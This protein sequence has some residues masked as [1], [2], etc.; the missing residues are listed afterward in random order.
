M[1]MGA[2]QGLIGQ[3]QSAAATPYQNYGGQQ[4]ADLTGNQNAGIN[5]IASS[6]GIQNPYLSAAGN[7]ANIGASP[8]SSSSIQGYMNPYT[9]NVINA[10]MAQSQQQQQIA[11]NQLQGNATAMGGLGNNRLGV[12]QAQLAKN[13]DMNNQSTIANLNSQNYQQALGAAQGDA[14]ADIALRVENRHQHA[15]RYVAHGI[16]RSAIS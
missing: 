7:Y 4:V 6:Q 2:Y 15:D 11:Q 3:A 16:L 14:L 12:L 9:S 13:Y 5:T 1:A 8:I 10:T